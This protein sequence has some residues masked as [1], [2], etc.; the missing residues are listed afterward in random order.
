MPGAPWEAPGAPA[1]SSKPLTDLALRAL[2]LFQAFLLALAPALGQTSEAGAG[3]HYDVDRQD[4]WIRIYV[5]RAGLLSF[6]GHD[7]LISTSVIDGGL[8]YT[9]PP[10]LD[11]AFRLTIPVDALV[12]DD[13]EQRKQVGGRFS[14]LVPDKDRK[15]T[16]RNMLSAKVL[17]A[18][19]YPEIEITGHWTGSLPSR[20]EVAASIGLGDT[21][22]QYRVP[23]DI[24]G[25]P[26]RWVVTGSLHLEQSDLGIT[27][28]SIGG[29]LLKV[30][31]GVDV[32]FSLAFVPTEN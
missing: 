27:P 26:A 25:Q 32:R 22:R 10:A 23:V 15:G 18:A 28:V 29:G 30:A 9:P 3:T 1:M 8:T 5:Y 17:D 16:R 31:D 14:G 21:H 12:V 20:G 2:G 19:H 6:L 4:S 13:P 11:A 7:H 24:R